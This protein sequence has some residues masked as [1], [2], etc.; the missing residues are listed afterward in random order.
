MAD[1]S[2]ATS[3]EYSIIAVL[4]SIGVIA[5]LILIGPQVVAMLTDAG[6]AF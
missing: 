2:G 4:I 3:I 6:A 1:E 5:A